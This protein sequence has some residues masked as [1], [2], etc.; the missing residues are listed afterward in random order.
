MASISPPRARR[1][2]P[3]IALFMLLAA[4]ALSPAAEAGVRSSAS[5]NYK[6]TRFDFHA[7]GQL[8]GGRFAAA[9]SPTDALWEGEVFTDDSELA[10]LGKVGDASLKIHRHGTSGEV[11]AKT[12]VESKFTGFHRETTACEKELESAHTESS[13]TEGG[14]T[15][16]T[17]LVDIAG[18]VGNRVRI[19]WNFFQDNGD[20]L[21]PNTFRCGEPFSFSDPAAGV[22]CKGSTA[23]LAKLTAK[24]VKLPFFC[25]STATTPP[26]G[27]N[28][29]RYGSTVTA[30]GALFL[31]RTKMH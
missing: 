4:L 20:R 17:A 16:M 6:V 23:N 5:F 27:T 30:K 9:C 26:P 24:K 11:E 18:G 14:E 21:V 25:L 15:E 10:S 2:A 3:S 13:C 12:S 31:T 22:N 7:S 8:S 28:Y 29:T 1:A 19:T